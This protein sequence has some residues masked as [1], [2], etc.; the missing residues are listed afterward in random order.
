[1]NQT[2]TLLTEL[3]QQGVKLWVDGEQLRVNAPR[4]ALTP[5]LTDRLKAQKSELLTLLRQQQTAP[6]IPAIQPVA[7]T[8]PLPLSFAQQR[9][10][11]LNRLGNGEAYNM[12][13]RIALRG[14]LNQA[15]FAQSLT[16][17]IRRHE[18]LRTTFTTIEGEA[19]Q[20]IQDD[21]T[22]TLPLIDLTAL[23][24]TACEAAIAARAAQEALQP[25]DLERDPL[26]RAALLWLAENEHLLLLTLHH[27]AGDGWS[28]EVLSRELATLYP[29]FL[30]KQ[31]ASLPP[32]SI[33]YA[34]FAQWQRQWLQ[35]DV[36]A[37]QL[38][39]WR[40]QLTGAPP[41]LELPTDRPRPPVQSF[42]GA[43]VAFTIPT[44]LTQ[45][46]RRLSR[47]A[48]ATLFMTLLAAF[49]VLL[50]RYTGQPDIVVDTPIAGRNH[51]EIEPL[52]GFF[53]NTLVLRTDLTGAASFLDLLGRVRQVVEGAF[54]HQDAPF[55]QLVEALQPERNLA[56]NPLSQVSFALQNRAMTP[57]TVA[58]L[59]INPPS[60]EVQTVRADLELFLFESDQSLS[61]ECVYSTALFDAATI[62]RLLGHYQTLLTAIAQNPAQPLTE[63]PLLTAAERHQLLIDWNATAAPYPADRCIHQLFA[64]QAARTPDAMALSVAG[65]EIE[66]LRGSEIARADGQSLNLS[67]SQSLTY[68]ELNDRANQLAHHLQAL[69]VGPESLVG[70]GLS[71]SPAMVI[72]LL[73]VLKAGGAY[74]PLDANYPA[75]RLRFM[76]QDAQPAVLIADDALLAKVDQQPTSCPIINLAQAWPAIAQQ[77]TTNPS[78]AVEPE[79]LAYVIYTSGSTGNPK[80]VMIPH[81]ALVNHGTAMVREF[82]LTAQ[83][84]VLQFAAFSFDVAAEEIF[85]TWLAGAAVVL[86]P[87]QPLLAVADLL[88]LVTEQGISVL[89]LPASYWHEW[90]LQLDENPVPA[91]VRLVVVGSE[92]VAGNRLASWQAH[93]GNRAIAWRNAYGLSETTI[94]STLYTPA[95]G[96]TTFPDAVPIGR[97]LANTQLYILDSAGHPAPI[98][99]PGELYIGGAG[100][101]R[102]YLNRPDLTDFRFVIL[103]FGLN[104]G[105]AAQNPKSKIQNHKSYKTG[106]RARYRADGN[107]EFFGRAD[108]QVKIRGFRV[109]P[110]AIES[111]LSEQPQVAEAV[112]IDQTDASGNKSLVAYVVPYTGLTGDRVTE[113]HPI[114]QSPNHP[115]TQSPLLTCAN[116]S[117]PACPIT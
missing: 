14:P 18:S 16:A 117:K 55:E 28:M 101:A 3:N 87:A 39:Y 57:T 34:D 72:A 24:P 103:D 13:A 74:M 60:M 48:E 92:K 49:K 97:P 7:R 62:E 105:D 42:Q 50:A 69:G 114:T 116:S 37:Q 29:A 46:L 115:I 76:L 44:A 84:R 78:S 113:D 41:L 79:N 94:T 23:P 86:P 53:V 68:G 99:V 71:R 73:G 75:E 81:R 40:Q 100:V 8:A 54:A 17:I 45:S 2:L 64:E 47:Q 108:S 32:L 58:G 33:Q 56:Y 59:Q 91:P 6:R 25:F 89:N 9:L 102:G 19:L 36:V 63:L 111:V 30:Q 26:V 38:A 82:G 106:D 27:I 83:D 31:P 96:Q 11:F 10:W 52:I 95:V 65:Q 67:I 90:V 93:V 85:P 35:G 5:T 110:S 104:A 20:V 66:R 77:S 1:M 21:F 15:A 107:I 70:I 4:G 112:V 109:E 22:F 80:G 98:G 51:T 43:K 61:G 88:G 12:P